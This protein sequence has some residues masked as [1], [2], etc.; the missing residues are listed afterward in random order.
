VYVLFFINVETRRVHIA[1]MT[2]HP[3]RAWVA[4]QA[5]NTAMF[6]GE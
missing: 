5:R 1:G 2:A 3:D 4:Q 6:F